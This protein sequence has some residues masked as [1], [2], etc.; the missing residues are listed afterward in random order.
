MGI[1]KCSGDFFDTILGSFSYCPILDI[2]VQ[3]GRGIYRLGL[4]IP[5]LLHWHDACDPDTD[6]CCSRRIGKE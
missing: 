6:K 3:H 1:V 4:P 2:F 5:G